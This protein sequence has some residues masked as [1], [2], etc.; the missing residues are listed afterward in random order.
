MMK[1]RILA[2]LCALMLLCLAA[3][4][5][6]AEASRP[7]NYNLV[8]DEAGLMGVEMSAA[9]DAKAWEISL[10]NNLE[11]CILVL[12]GTGG[13]PLKY[14]AADYWDENGYGY[15][16][17]H[18]GVMLAL[19]LAER[20][21]FILTT[22]DGIRIFTDYGVRVIGDEIVPYLSN[23]RYY[24]AFDRYL[25]LAG[26]FAVEANTNQ[27]YDTNH[28]YRGKPKT[29]AEKLGMAAPIGLVTSLLTTLFGM[30]SMKKGMHTVHR[31]HGAAQYARRESMRMSRQADVFLYHNRHV[32]RLPEPR[33][34]GGGGGGGSTTFTSSSGVTHGG[35][36]G[37][38]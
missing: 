1:R 12:N 31:K 11:A 32:E 13:K 19:D 29:L 3:L 30:G 36:G 26:E 34:G 22:G 35:G 9:L 10:A 25:D 38:F 37:K 18:D 24:E 4:P 14:Y 20:D 7:G 6:L 21:W 33:S 5:A 8:L 27:P 28:E 16:P 23:G 2:L 15:G 17:G